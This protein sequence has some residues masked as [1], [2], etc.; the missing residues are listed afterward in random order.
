MVKFTKFR[1]EA[2]KRVSLP[3][4]P[5]YGMGLKQHPIDH[6]MLS[7]KRTKNKY[8]SDARNTSLKEKMKRKD[9]TYTKLPLP[10]KKPTRRLTI[11][12]HDTSASSNHNNQ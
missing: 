5:E 9:V 6:M 10:T 2:F 8:I 4:T 7:I 3:A 11:Y 12:P 1:A